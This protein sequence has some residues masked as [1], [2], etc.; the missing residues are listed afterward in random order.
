[1][2]IQKSLF[3]RVNHYQTKYKEVSKS[4]QEQMTTNLKLMLKLGVKLDENG[5]LTEAKG[6]EV[7]HP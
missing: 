2:R 3:E 4:L 1:M 6:D 5:A 7:V